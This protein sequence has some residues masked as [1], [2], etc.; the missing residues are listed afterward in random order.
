MILR[1]EHN[2][3]HVDVWGGDMSLVVILC[4][5]SSCDI[6]RSHIHH[7]LVFEKSE[8]LVK[9]WTSSPI[10]VKPYSPTFV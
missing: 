3:T 1:G 4:K 2:E 6:C 5:E 7:L 8:L 9:I 10:G